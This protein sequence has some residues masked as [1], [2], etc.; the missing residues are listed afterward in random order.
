L[1]NLLISQWSFGCIKSSSKI[2][3]EWVLKG[4]LNSSLK[5]LKVAVIAVKISVFLKLK[6]LENLLVTGFKI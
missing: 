4:F 2:L 6:N 1:I 5:G 3:F